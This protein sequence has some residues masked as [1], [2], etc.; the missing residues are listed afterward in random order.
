MGLG[1]TLLMGEEGWMNLARTKTFAPMP[2]CFVC[3]LHP[4]GIFMKGSVT[5]EENFFMTEKGKSCA[6]VPAL[7]KLSTNKQQE[8]EGKR[9]NLN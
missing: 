1:W 3:N 2:W 8:K 5:F 4:C 7:P 9:I 6:K